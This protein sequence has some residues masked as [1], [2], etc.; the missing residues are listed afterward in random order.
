MESGASIG[1]IM[2]WGDRILGEEVLLRPGYLFVVCM[3]GVLNVSMPEGGARIKHSHTLLLQPGKRFRLKS[4]EG[5]TILLAEFDQQAVICGCLPAFIGNPMMLDFFLKAKN[6]T[7]HLAFLDLEG[8]TENMLTLFLYLRM[9]TEGGNA[10]D[11]LIALAL[12]CELLEAISRGCFMHSVL[13]HEL[14]QEPFQRICECLLRQRGLPSLQEVAEE[15]H[16]HP[17]TVSR[18]LR[19]GCGMGYGKLRQ[20]IR[21]SFAAQS[22]RHERDTVRM[23]AKEAGYTNMTNFYRQFKEIYGILPAEYQALFL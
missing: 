14:M 3:D 18:I 11:N 15:H 19:Q 9:Y 16:Y 10:K 12:L 17:N 13:T 4:G 23:A 8:L 20:T 6:E 1:R 22:L 21:V 7:D 5:A 2:A